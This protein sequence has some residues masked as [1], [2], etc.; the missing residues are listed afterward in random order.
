[1]DI[2]SL[3]EGEKKINN[4]LCLTLRE[5]VSTYGQKWAD[6]I[7]GPDD[8]TVLVL[9]CWVD[10]PNQYISCPNPSFLKIVDV[11]R[12]GEVGCTQSARQSHIHQQVAL[13][14][15]VITDLS[16]MSWNDVKWRLRKRGQ[17]HNQ[18]KRFYW[19]VKE[20]YRL[21]WAFEQLLPAGLIWHVYVCFTSLHWGHFKCETASAVIIIWSRNISYG[22][23]L[24]DWIQ[25][26]SIITIFSIFSIYI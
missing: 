7:N 26:S 3:L 22:S 4:N 16:L 14:R 19:T 10:E 25:Q 2:A 8:R 23:K 11:G 5:I 6:A 20:H 17:Y 12:A 1:M 13:P 21:N 9:S 15:P 18:C 24:T